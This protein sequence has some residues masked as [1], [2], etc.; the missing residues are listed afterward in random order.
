MEAAD[1]V[2]RVEEFTVESADGDKRRRPRA[3]RIEDVARE[4]IAAAVRWAPG[5]AGSL[6]EDARL[7]HAHL[8]ATLAA[9]REGD[10]SG[11]HASVIVDVAG[12]LSSRHDDGPEG[13]ARHAAMCAALE[14]RVL[15]VAC[16]G[17]VSQTRA[18][19]KRALLALDAEGVEQRR[20]QQRCTRDV[21]II[22]EADGISV[23]LARMSTPAARALMEAV[24]REA[25]AIEDESLSIG[26]RRAQ[27]LA[28]LV[29]GGVA[30]AVRLDV[31]IPAVD[32][33]G[34]SPASLADAIRA[35]MGNATID[36]AEVAAED[37][38]ELLSDPDV[39]VTLRKFLAD[40]VTGVLS[41]CGRTSYRLPA[42]L[43]EFIIR[44]DATC[45]FPG[46][47]RAARFGQVDHARP[48]DSG[49]GTDPDNL[50][51]LCVRHHLLKTHAEWQIDL[52]RADGSCAW[53]SPQGRRYRCRADSIVESTTSRHF[54]RVVAAALSSGHPPR[55]RGRVRIEYHGRRHP[56]PPPF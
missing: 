30:P 45:R 41:G 9:L 27:A 42:R 20:R 56:E 33:D 47:G 38:A 26:E 22:E 1:R 50:G 46:C 34:L 52:S 55:R 13:T 10:I 35:G 36:G 12:Q 40:P 11:R 37:L 32:S 25:A 44:R 31:V 18:A 28:A 49:G 7:L 5:H 15:R 2:P 3:I 19:A 24:G 29:F 17:T 23:L 4:E 39:E 6:I 16:R 14:Q 54:A 8:P 51:A 53:T 48:W 43:R 21:R